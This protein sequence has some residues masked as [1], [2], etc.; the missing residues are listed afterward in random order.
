MY[1]QTNAHQ[2][3]QEHQAAPEVQ[4]DQAGQA[5]LEAPVAQADHVS[6]APDADA[7][8]MLLSDYPII[9]IVVHCTYA[10]LHRGDDNMVIV[11]HVSACAINLCT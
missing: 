3:V 2:A 8:L 11:V 7:L 4:E 9:I 1:Q 6:S 5:D 10:A